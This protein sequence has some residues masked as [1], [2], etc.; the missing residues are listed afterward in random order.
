MSICGGKTRGLKRPHSALRQMTGADSQPQDM[1]T[2]IDPQSGHRLVLP[3]V[4]GF[5]EF[6]TP[7]V[8]AIIMGQPDPYRPRAE[9]QEGNPY[10]PPVGCLEDTDVDDHTFVERQVSPDGGDNVDH[11]DDPHGIP[12]SHGRYNTASIRGYRTA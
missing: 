4:P 2:T 11:G 9:T 6:D 7:L 8:A 5:L 10:G 1:R 3:H 12:Q